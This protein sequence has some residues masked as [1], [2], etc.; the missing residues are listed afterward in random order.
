[1]SFNSRHPFGWDLPPGCSM[2]D[3]DRAMGGDDEPM[4]EC[5][6]CS[7]YGTIGSNDDE[8]PMCKGDGVIPQTEED[9]LDKELDK[10]DRQRDAEIDRR[11]GL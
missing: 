5:P 11:M 1:M 10:A 8:C 9:V 6:R 7:G 3:I 4:K 2:R